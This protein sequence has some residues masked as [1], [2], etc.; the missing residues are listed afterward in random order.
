MN[1]DMGLKGET[2]MSEMVIGAAYKVANGLGT[3]FLEKVY[4]NALSIELRRAGLAVEQQ[5]QMQVWYQGEIVGFYQADLV[6]NRSMVVELKA[7]PSLERLHRAQCLN[8]LRAARMRTGLVINFGRPRV[9]V[10][11]VICH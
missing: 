1:T 8:Y 6:V 3:G 2:G 10:Q 5:K 7:V 4:E 9:E 11:R